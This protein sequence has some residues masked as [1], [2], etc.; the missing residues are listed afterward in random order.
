MRCPPP[1]AGAWTAPWLRKY[2]YIYI[3]KD[4]DIDIYMLMLRHTPP[5]SQVHGRP[6]RCERSAHGGQGLVR[7]KRN[8]D[9]LR[10]KGY[11]LT[12]NPNP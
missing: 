1:V 9:R 10:V 2:I 5:L 12:P 7:R 6:S 3:G 8:S 4:I 11:G